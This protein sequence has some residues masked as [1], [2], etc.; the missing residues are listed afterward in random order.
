[1]SDPEK[2]AE[3]DC[4]THDGQGIAATPSEDHV[5]PGKLAPTR[6][7]RFVHSL[8]TIAAQCMG[9]GDSAAAKD[10]TPG[11]AGSATTDAANKTVEHTQPDC[12]DVQN[13]TDADVSNDGNGN[14][15]KSN[16]GHCAD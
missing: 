2:P 9:I 14:G 10:G 15:P 7:E 12:S 1:M 3:P 8:S 13:H 16:R 6:W 4:R 5:N 11:A